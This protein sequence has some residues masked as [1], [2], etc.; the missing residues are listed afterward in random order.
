MNPPGPR[1]AYG[2]GDPRDRDAERRGRG[3]DRLGAAPVGASGTAEG[4]GPDA[5]GG[6]GAV[7]GAVA[8]VNSS[9]NV[10]NW[11]RSGSARRCS[12][13][14]PKAIASWAPSFG[15]PPAAWTSRTQRTW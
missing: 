4:S 3:E 6:E 10:S 15:S 9:R 14:S 12:S 7:G 2:G 1:A 8:R 13:S 5:F 11:R